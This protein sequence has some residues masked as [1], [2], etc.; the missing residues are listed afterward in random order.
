MW[1]RLDTTDRSTYPPEGEIVKVI[2]ASGDER[3]LILQDGLFWLPN[4]SMYV[5]F[6]PEF[7]KRMGT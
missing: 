4:M 7:W 3:E 1:T 5:Y 6:V 2:T